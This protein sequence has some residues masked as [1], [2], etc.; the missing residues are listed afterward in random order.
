MSASAGWTFI[1]SGVKVRVTILA[2]ERGVVI[3]FLERLP[4]PVDG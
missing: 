3:R 2:H 4:S 1:S